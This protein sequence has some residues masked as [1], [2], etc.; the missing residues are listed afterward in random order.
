VHPP[1]VEVITPKESNMGTKDKA[2]NRAQDLKGKAKEAV[3]SATGNE[4]LR[5]E[6]KGDQTKSA[7]KDSGENL[8]DAASNVKDAFEGH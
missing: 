6:G 8:K 7:L 2:S 1:N 3:G 5:R 4:D